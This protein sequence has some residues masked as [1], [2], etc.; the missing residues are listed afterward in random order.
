MPKILNDFAFGPTTVVAV[1]IGQKG[2]VTTI[3]RF[4]EGDMW[5]G[6]YLGASLGGDP[7]KRVIGCMKDE[8]WHG[9]PINDLGS[10]SAMVVIGCTRKAAVRRGY[11]VVELAKRLDTLG[12]R[13][14]KV[15]GEEPCLLPQSLPQFQK[16]VVLVEAI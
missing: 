9:N 11:F 8:R 5:V 1:G 13:N 10:R 12:A 7:Y 15:T 16:E 6:S 3:V 2:A 14:I 4:V